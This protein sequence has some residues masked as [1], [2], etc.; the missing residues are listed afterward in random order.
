MARSSIIRWIVGDQRGVRQVVDVVAGD[1]RRDPAGAGGH[2]VVAGR[3]GADPV[4][5]DEVL[6]GGV[7][8]DA[9]P[10]A[11]AHARQV[12][13]VDEPVVGKRQ[14]G[15]GVVTQP[16]TVVLCGRTSPGERF[17]GVGGA[18]RAVPERYAV[19]G[20]LVDGRCAGPDQRRAACRAGLRLGVGEAVVEA[21][22]G[23]FGQGQDVF[24]AEP[25][26]MTHRDEPPRRVMGR[27]RGRAAVSLAGA[28]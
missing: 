5:A 23:V 11:G 4:G 21:G 14:V 9:D 25:E 8:V 27:K 10:V 6:V 20:E 18:V 3:H 15:A 13:Q 1:G 17:G 16:I 7:D 28:S 19:G 22:E 24:E 2:E 12:Q 26:A